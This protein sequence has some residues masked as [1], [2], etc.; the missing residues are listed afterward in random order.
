[1]RLSVRAKKSLIFVH[2][3]MGVMLCTLF[4]LWFVSGVVMMYWDFPSVRAEDRLD[5]A[6]TLDV[7]H[8]RLSAAEAFSALHTSQ[9]SSQIRLNSFDGRPA[10]HFRIGR[11]ERIVYADTGQEQTGVDSTMA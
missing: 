7:L 11:N 10:Y 8:V 4:L 2:R 3:W 1:M 5:R 9:T 6:P